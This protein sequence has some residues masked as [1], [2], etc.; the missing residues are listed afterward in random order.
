[1]SIKFPSRF[2]SA[3]EFINTDKILYE[4]NDFNLKVSRVENQFNIFIFQIV[5]PK[6]PHFRLKGRNKKGGLP[7]GTGNI[8]VTHP[9]WR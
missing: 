1:M 9:E 2:Q 6:Q 3:G 4:K 8:D 7:H 5:H